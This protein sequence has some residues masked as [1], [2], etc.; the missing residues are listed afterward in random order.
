MSDI[1]VFVQARPLPNGSG[2]YADRHCRCGMCFDAEGR[3]VSVTV[4]DLARLKAD[5]ML[6]V[7]EVDAPTEPP[8]TEAS[9][10]AE[11]EAPRA[12]ASAPEPDKSATKTADKKAG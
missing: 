9:E 10:A 4:D 1:S 2:V 8:Q 3:T 12:D 11:P 7:T 5:P 6:V